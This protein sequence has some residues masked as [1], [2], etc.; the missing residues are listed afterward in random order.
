M[1]DD[2]LPAMLG[3]GHVSANDL[4]SLLAR[5]DGPTDEITPFLANDRPAVLVIRADPNSAVRAM[6]RRAWG[7]THRT[8]VWY[9][10]GVGLR[11]GRAAYHK[12]EH[13]AAGRRQPDLPP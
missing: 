5:T 8:I 4:Q 1:T 6:E 2:D 13:G 12:R 7:G 11:G 3:S 9:G 10:D